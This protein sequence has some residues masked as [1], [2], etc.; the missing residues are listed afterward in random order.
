MPLQPYTKSEFI[1]KIHLGRKKE[2]ILLL[3]E[4]WELPPANLCMEVELLC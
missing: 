3:G 2:T 4:I 1:Q